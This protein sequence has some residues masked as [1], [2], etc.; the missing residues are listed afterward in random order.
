MRLSQPRITPTANEEWT[1]EQAA[2]MA[3]LVEHGS[4]FN[5]FRTMVRHPEAFRAF[6]TWGNYVLSQKNA[7]PARE[8]EIAILRIGWLCRAGY[9]WGQHVVIGKRSGLTDAEVEA[10]KVGEGT[11][12]WS[13]A[14]AAILAA[15][16]E[17]HADQFISDATWARLAAHFDEKQRV[18]LVY[19]VGQYTQVSMLLNSF[20]VQPDVGLAIDPAIDGR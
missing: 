4:A 7:L 12:D 2:L 14:D 17:L 15:C 9:E 13:A 20:G 5:I 1:P 16:D 8:R 10:I 3:P 11:P 18:D 6:L 19:T